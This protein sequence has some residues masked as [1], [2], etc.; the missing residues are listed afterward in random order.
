MRLGSETS[1]VV[2][3]IYAVPSLAAAPYYN[4]ASF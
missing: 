2:G 4:S 1:I 3:V